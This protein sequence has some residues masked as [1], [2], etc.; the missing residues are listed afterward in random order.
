MNFLEKDSDMYRIVGCAFEVYNTLHDGYL[1]SVYER[2]LEWEILEAGF[3]VRCQ[4]GIPVF[5]KGINLNRNFCADLIVD[6]RI[7][8]ELKAVSTL[9]ARHEMQLRNYLKSTGMQEGLLINFGHE[10]RLEWRAIS[11]IQSL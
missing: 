4:V 8:I 6:N 2:A 3:T 11:P 9:H 10:K 7:V 5:Y 1:E